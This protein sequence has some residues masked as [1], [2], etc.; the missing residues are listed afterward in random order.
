MTAG[1]RLYPVADALQALQV[2]GHAP[3]PSPGDLRAL[4]PG[5]EGVLRRALAADRAERYPT[6]RALQLD[7]EDVARSAGLAVSDMPVVALLAALFPELALDLDQPRAERP[8]VVVVDDE[9]DMLELIARI[10]KP[11]ADVRTARSVADAVRL[12][13]AA[14]CDLVLADERMPD[15]PGIDLL[16]R[17]AR[18]SPS[19][20]RILMSAYADVDLLVSAINR[21]KVDRF[22]VK[23]F[24]PDELRSMVEDALAR[25]P[26]LDWTTAEIFAPP[27]APPE[28]PAGPPPVALPWESLRRLTDGVREDALSCALLVGVA[29]QP[30]GGD[31]QVAIQWVLERRV[32]HCWLH[33]EGRAIAVLVPGI[34]SSFAAALAGELRDAA[35]GVVGT[36]LAV[37]IAELPAGDDLADLGR[38]VERAA[39]QAWLQ[40]ADERAE[41]EP[42]DPTDA[43]DAVEPREALEPEPV[44]PLTVP[45]A[46]RGEAT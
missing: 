12:L 15:E 1:G 28:R 41:P 46:G 45:A 22:L 30:V 36:R 37:A 38:Q 9:P 4:P 29:D 14:R 18:E 39:V 23:P 43:G 19:T 16:A 7:V 44:E 17:V 8:S 35:A 26:R 10:L 5:W 40:E 21:G 42:I 32:P 24:A 3:I 20:V 33:V 2:I 11:S 6:A 13:A 31:E 27:S 34:A 25:A